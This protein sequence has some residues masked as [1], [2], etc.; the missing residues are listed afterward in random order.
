MFITSRNMLSLNSSLSRSRR[1]DC[2]SDRLLNE[3]LSRQ[4]AS[5]PVVTE[6]YRLGVR[7]D[8]VTRIAQI[9]SNIKDSYNNNAE[10]E[11]HFVTSNISFLENH[12]LNFAYGA[13][14]IV[15]PIFVSSKYRLNCGR[16]LHSNNE[17][18][19]NTF[20]DVFDS[21]STNRRQACD[22]T[23]S[24]HSDQRGPTDL[25]SASLLLHLLMEKALDHASLYRSTSKN[26]T[27][28]DSFSLN[29]A[30]Q[31]SSHF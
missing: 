31:R 26:L 9:R 25:F 30:C 21:S 12:Y 23:W 6:R 7:L 5:L 24:V 27:R 3:A 13:I 28:S 1:W 20:L 19:V 15:D 2:T 11:F 14:G 16:D 18:I 29:V 4:Q 22:I 10:N 17:T 8:Y